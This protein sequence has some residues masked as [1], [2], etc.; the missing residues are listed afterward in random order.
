MPAR[1]A[2]ENWCPETISLCATLLI[3]ANRK[4]KQVLRDR[5][6][7]VVHKVRTYYLDFHHLTFPPH[8]PVLFLSVLTFDQPFFSSYLFVFN[9]RLRNQYDFDVVSYVSLRGDSGNGRVY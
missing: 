2:N 1:E 3:G 9:L 8:Q 6:T 4:W 7:R 5:V